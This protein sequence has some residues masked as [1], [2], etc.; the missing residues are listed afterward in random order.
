MYSAADQQFWIISPTNHLHKKK[1]HD[2]DSI[3]K[4]KVVKISSS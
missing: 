2:S 1:K 4:L 3:K